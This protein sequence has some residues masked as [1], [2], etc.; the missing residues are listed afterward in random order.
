MV[1]EVTGVTVYLDILFL[2]NFSMD[3]LTLWAVCAV[4]GR[5]VWRGRILAAALLGASGATASVLLPRM[6]DPVR[7]G[8]GVLL[9]AVMG[10]VCFGFYGWGGLFRNAVLIW[11]AGSLLGGVMTALFSLGTPVFSGGDGFPAAYLLCALF[12]F[13]WTR[14][15]RG[16]SGTREARIVVT[17]GGITAEM[18]GLCDTGSF[19]CDPIGGEPAVLVKRRAL[20]ELGIL[21]E[22]AAR[23]ESTGL[24]LRMIPVKGVGGERLLPGFLPDRILIGGV[25]RAAAVA[26]DGEGERYGEAD[27]LIPG[28]LIP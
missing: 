20:G 10:L 16:G 22:R 12:S 11:G 24:R 8:A 18:N 7:V 14:I 3:L 27:A 23:G 15:R 25:E 2:V 19:A 26:V 21:A 4:C 5:R 13:L 28:P 9:A 6:G 17:A 1:R